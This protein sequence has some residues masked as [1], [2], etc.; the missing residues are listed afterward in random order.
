[1]AIIEY[2][3]GSEEYINRNFRAIYNLNGIVGETSQNAEVR[4]A[5]LELRSLSRQAARNDPHVQGYLSQIQSQVVG[6]KGIQMKIDL[7]CKGRGSTESSMRSK[8]EEIEQ[9]WYEWT[10]GKVDAADSCTWTKLQRMIIRS[11]AESGEVFLHFVPFPDGDF[12]LEIIE[13]DQL[14]HNYEYTRDKDGNK[15]ELGIK[16]DKWGRRQ[17]YAFYSYHPGDLYQDPN[18]G[19]VNN[20]QYFFAPAKDILHIYKLDRPGQLRGIPWTTPV[21]ELMA[22]LAGY[23]RNTAV[24]ARATAGG[25]AYVKQNEDSTGDVVSDHE[26]SRGEKINEIVPGRVEYLDPGQDLVVPDFHAPNN[27]HEIYMQTTLMSAS[28]GL[29]MA[30]ESI[31]GNYT[32]SNYSS[33]RMSLIRE[34]D[35]LR[36]AQA[37]LIE[38]LCQPV[39]SA[40]INHQRV[41]GEI[42]LTN[43]QYKQLSKGSSINWMGRGWPWVDPLKDAQAAK[44]AIDS[45]FRSTSEVVAEQG[46]DFEKVS[47]ERRRDEDIIESLELTEQTIESTIVA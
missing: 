32:K 46:R 43:E 10:S 45:G 2:A 25:V 16:L 7:R 18:L 26:T 23:E 47:R 30:Y 28:V 35:N 38:E 8:S 37:L 15:W 21:L 12:R 1:M 20:R 13:C 29:G 4:G 34:R 22:H 19:N 9:K 36:I 40:W 6:N 42:E 17:Q 11:V 33:S 39:F 41:T 44:I 14:D 27:E 31:S 5:L 3:Y 24:R